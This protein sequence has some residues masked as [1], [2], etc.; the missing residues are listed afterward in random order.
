MWR[1]NL[2]L[3]STFPIKLYQSEKDPTVGQ[4]SG[5]DLNSEREI[6]SSSFT[7]NMNNIQL[8]TKLIVTT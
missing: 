8:A 4:I 7:K 3:Q 1:Q 6:N 2:S 5:K